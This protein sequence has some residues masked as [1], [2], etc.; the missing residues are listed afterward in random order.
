MEYIEHIASQYSQPIYV[1]V[2]QPTKFK[3]LQ[4]VDALSYAIF[5]KFEHSNDIF[6]DI[7]EGSVVIYEK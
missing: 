3:G 1:Q 2:A 7:I 5:Q 6:Y 4:V